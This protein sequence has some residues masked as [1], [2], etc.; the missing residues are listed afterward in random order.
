[1]P[2]LS[3]VPVPAPRSLIVAVP[4]LV[5]VMPLFIVTV[6]E[7]VMLVVESMARSVLTVTGA[8]TVPEP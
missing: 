2:S 4:L 1:M 6:P 5:K 8:D 7:M 3:K